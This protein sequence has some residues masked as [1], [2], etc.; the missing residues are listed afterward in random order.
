MFSQWKEDWFKKQMDI[1]E[2]NSYITTFCPYCKREHSII[3]IDYL[4]E[5]NE[6]ILYCNHFED[7]F[8]S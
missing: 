8:R 3:E 6:S 2:P 4:T 7:H 1:N 5:D